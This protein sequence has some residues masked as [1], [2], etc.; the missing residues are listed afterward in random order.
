MNKNKMGAAMEAIGVLAETSLVYL[1]AIM[2]AGAT[3]Q[4][5]QILVNGYI[6]GIL[7]PNPNKEEEDDTE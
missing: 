3:P 4:E 5:A 6:R 1:R 2:N 7:A